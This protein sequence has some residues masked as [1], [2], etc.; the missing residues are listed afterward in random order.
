M[1]TICLSKAFLEACPKRPFL[2]SESCP[3]HP[4]L[5][6]EACSKRLGLFSKLVLNVQVH[7]QERVHINFQTLILNVQD[8]FQKRVLNIHIHFQMFLQNF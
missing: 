8:Y 7:F 5:F 2:F 1:L 4:C 6:S 3:K